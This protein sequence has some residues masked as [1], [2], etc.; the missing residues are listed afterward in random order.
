MLLLHPAVPLLP[1]AL[2]HLQNDKETIA[3]A[4]FFV[5]SHGSYY[6]PVRCM[7][8]G[9]EK[10]GKGVKKGRGGKEMG[11]QEGEINKAKNGGWHTGERGGERIGRAGGG[12]KKAFLRAGEE[13]TGR[14]NRRR[15]GPLPPFSSSLPSGGVMAPFL[16]GGERGGGSRL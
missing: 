9:S 11:V 4:S 15:L 14:K 1:A 13:E 2:P 12:E 10:R 3:L 8:K 6:P 5:V 16:Q 7:T